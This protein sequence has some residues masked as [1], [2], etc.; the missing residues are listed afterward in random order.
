MTKYSIRRL[1]ITRDNTLL[2]IIT[3]TDLARRLYEK[4]KADP[5]LRAMSRFVDVEK[6]G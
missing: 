2:G 3:S 5:S 4:N 6:L 1:P